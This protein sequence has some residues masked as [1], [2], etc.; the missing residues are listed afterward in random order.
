[1][2]LNPRQSAIFDK[3]RVCKKIPSLETE[4]HD[5]S[6]DPPK[7]KWPWHIHTQMGVW[8]VQRTLTLEQLKM[9]AYSTGVQGQA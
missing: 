5:R 1:M 7:D 3:D 9:I 6:K 2:I 4:K 8:E